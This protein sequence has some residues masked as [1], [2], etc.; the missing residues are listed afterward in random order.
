M[1]ARTKNRYYCGTGVL[2]HKASLSTVMYRLK[3]KTLI[4]I[5]HDGKEY[6]GSN[7]ATDNYIF[8]SAKNAGPLMERN[9]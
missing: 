6:A 9:D 8:G 2:A 5:V 4:T 7:P 3:G 1:I